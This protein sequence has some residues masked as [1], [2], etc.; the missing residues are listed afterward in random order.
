MELFRGRRLWAEKREV[1]LPTG[2]IREKV[3]IHPGNA[4]AILPIEGDSVKLLRQY[5]YP[6]EQ[7]IV[8]APAG[9]L[10]PGEEPA[11]C[12][13]RELIEET[14]FAATTIE[15]RGFI[16]TTPG[17]TDEKIWLFEAHGLTPSSEYGMDEDEIIDVIDVPVN[18]LDRLIHDGTIS[19]AKTIALICRC[20]R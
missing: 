15:P 12:A 1:R 6:V 20:L 7:Y 11:A 3:I 16:W 18:D 10:E 5:R 2:S 17:F 19:D 9:T 13:H 14:G 8:E 4:V